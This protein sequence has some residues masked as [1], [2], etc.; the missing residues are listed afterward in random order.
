MN[1]VENQFFSK[2]LKKPKGVKD[3]VLDTA[4]L[5]TLLGYCPKYKFTDLISSQSLAANL[6]IKSLYVKDERSRFDL[7]SFKSTGATYAIAKMAYNQ[8]RNKKKFTKEQL[9]KNL[10]H[11]TFVTASAGN[12]GIS[13]A[14]G[15]RLFGANAIVFLSKT[16]PKSFSKKLQGYGAKVIFSGKN[17]EE[18]MTAAENYSKE[19]NYILLSDSTWD[20]CSSGIDVMEGYLV[21]VEEIF[22]QFTELGQSN[23]ISHV[24]LQAGVGG[25]AAAIAGL[26]RK[27][28]D[29]QLKIIVVE[30]S[31]ANTLFE[32]IKS[33]KPT[34]VKG[35]D[36]VMGRLDCKEPSLSAFYSLA[37]T[38]NYFMHLDDKYVVKTIKNLK[39]FG[40]ETSA[41]GGAGLVGLNYAS[42][43]SLFGLNKNSSA[44][45]F[46]TEGAVLV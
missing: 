43:E 16:V 34:K 1:H 28:F 32:S 40:I 8:L 19:K 24:F 9:E 17:Y 26:I 38:S 46:L 6:G 3:L 27:K 37:L 15:A 5:K 7:G 33:G 41:S 12:H 45:I 22:D 25:F 13:M 35:D 18:S 29:K 39:N 36:S 2:G 11:H 4:L 10:S 23:P 42:Q 21:L 31:S 14:V 44:L 20:T 30:P